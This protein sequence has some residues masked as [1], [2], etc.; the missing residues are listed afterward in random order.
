LLASARRAPGV[1]WRPERLFREP[2]IVG[3]ACSKEACGLLLAC[4]YSNHMATMQL[5][6]ARIG[7]SRGVSLPAAACGATESATLS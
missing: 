5:K 2:A 6:A 4:A 7:N 3:C 1:E